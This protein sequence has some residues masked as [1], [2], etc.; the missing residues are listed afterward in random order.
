MKK[1]LFTVVTDTLFF[2]IIFSLIIFTL[3]NR[4]VTY[5][6]SLIIAL[7][8]SAIFSLLIFAL[9]KGKRSKRQTL[10]INK[11][12]L[13]NACVSLSIL[14]NTQLTEKFYNAYQNAK[15]EPKYTGKHLTLISG[16]KV[17][18]FF[19]P[20]GLKKSDIVKA[21]NLLDS[22]KGII[23]Y[24]QAQK[25]VLEFAKMFKKLTLLNCEDA[26]SFL[27]SNGI[28]L[29]INQEVSP[30][31]KRVKLSNLFIK[32]HAKKHFLFG[33]SFYLLSFISILKTY[34]LISGTIFL[35]FSAIC[36][37]FGKTEKET[38]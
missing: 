22:K 38:A 24:Y 7:S 13:E 21:F 8:C 19:S 30:T 32:K 11:K 2:F 6:Y 5:P 9:L 17:F 10:K 28:S 3:F 23:Y 27:T 12:T 16:E 36:L 4:F 1:T 33:V 14:N 37:L 20:D 26:Y 29:E 25:E 31:N 34:Y 15:K 18:I 35:I